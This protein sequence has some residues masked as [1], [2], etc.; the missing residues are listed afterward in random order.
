MKKILLLFFCILAQICSAQ[1]QTFEE[2]YESQFCRSVCGVKFGDSYENVKSS[3]EKKYGSPNALYTDEDNIVYLYK[4]Y[5]GI[6]FSVIDFSFQRDEKGSYL[7][8]CVMCINCRTAQDAKEKRE[9]IWSKIKG[10]YSPWNEGV[11]K[12]GFKYYSGGIS[13]IGYEDGFCVDIVK[14]SEPV[15]GYLY[16]ARIMYG[17]YNYVKEE[18]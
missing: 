9:K 13:P 10:K 3:L 11:D 12:N 2:F 1:E 6:L 8:Q 17:P 14:Y 15:D 7:N 4:S 5:C 16:Y 18:F